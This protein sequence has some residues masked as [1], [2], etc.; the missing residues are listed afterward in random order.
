MSAR[1][2]INGFGRIGRQILRHV[3]ASGL[4]IEPV[5]INAPSGTPAT[6]AHLFTYDS[7]FG[8]WPGPVHA[9]ASAIVVGEHVIRVTAERDPARLPWGA[10][11]VDVVAEASGAFTRARDALAHRHAGARTVIITAPAEGE[12]ITI[13]M[14]V[15][16]DRFDP[17]RHTIISGASCTTNCLAPLIRVLHERFG[18]RGGLVTAIHAYTRDQELLDGM[19]DD[20]RRARSAGQN[21]IPTETGAARALAKVL[22]SIGASIVGLAVR[23]PVPDVSVIDLDV[24]T[25]APAPVQAINEAFRDAA[26]S[27]RLRGILGVCDE[28]LVSSDFRGDARSCIVDAASTRAAGD[29]HVK[30]IAWYDNE[31]GYAARM[32]DLIA[33]ASG[34]TSKAPAVSAAGARSL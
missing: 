24:V 25:D 26:A 23:V 20:L 15:N 8:R 27:P 4:D 3:L 30:V 6:L 16:E 11:G 14:G 9:T 2:A 33:L 10:L 28:P 17:E 5:A 1:L 32:V 22:P 29:H 19:H 13:V 34:P 31:W 12:D 21:L 7:T 18:V